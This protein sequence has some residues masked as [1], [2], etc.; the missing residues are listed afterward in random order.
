MKRI[1]VVVCCGLLA[2]RVPIGFADTFCQ[3]PQPG[4]EVVFANG[5]LTAQDDANSALVKIHDNLQASLTPE[6]FN[7]LSFALAYNKTY[8][9]LADLYESMKQRVGSDNAGA[10]FFRWLGNLEPLPDSWQEEMKR[11]SAKFDFSTKVD[12]ADLN[13]HLSLYRSSMLGGKKVVAVCHSQGNFFCNAAYTILYH[14]DNPIHTRSF[15]IVSLAN[16]ASFVGGNGP[17]L[18]LVE[19]KVI[20]AISVATPLG[21]L[22]PLF[23]NVTNVGSAST[24]G[25]LVG[26]YI[27][28]DYLASGSRTD[29]RFIQDW[30][31]VN[32]GLE[33]PPQIVQDGIIT[34]ALTWGIQPDMDLHMFEPDGTH[35]FYA[36]R[37]GVS[38]FLDLDDTSSYGPEH[39][40]IAC[41]A[42]ET[43]VYRFGV[44]YFYGTGPETALV[45]ITAGNSVRSYSVPFSVA[46]GHD[47]DNSPVVVTSVAVSGDP[48]HGYTFDIQGLAQPQ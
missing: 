13:N 20:A 25:T 44:Q 30:I 5:I 1:L 46:V 43:G 32:N 16:P 26:H 24:T 35:V 15:G 12:L 29:P 48:T 28:E 10:S 39:I 33:Q 23:P 14:G 34:V 17:Y 9:A 37:Q 22:P 38:G 3:Q 47:G 21:I 7:K 42:I 31:M 27:I 4:T 41:S 45:Q 2:G 6:E 18:T 11:I 19:D 8:G 36:N 40:Y